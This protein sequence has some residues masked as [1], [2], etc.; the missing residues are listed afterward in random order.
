MKRSI[1]LACRA[2][3]A[4]VAAAAPALACAATVATG[5]ALAN[6]TFQS[7]LGGWTTSGVVGVRG[8]NDPINYGDA[9]DGGGNATFDGFFASRFAVLGDT[10]GFISPSDPV[11]DAQ[12]THWLTQSFVLD[13]RLEQAAVAGWRLSIYLSGAFDGRDSTGTRAN[14]VFSAQLLG[15]DAM[16]HPLF[17]MTSQGLG[18]CGPAVAPACGNAQKTVD[19]A[20]ARPFVLDGLQ[21]G[22]YTLT[23]SLQEALGGGPDD[24]RQSQTAAGIDDVRVMAFAELPAPGGMALLGAGLLGLGWAARRRRAARP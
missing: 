5:N 24:Y 9:R 21:P 15:P 18:T 4:A 17:S 22:R 13:S 16:L 12:G 8:A 7:G 6:G 3:L 11:S 10:S 19:R 14:D 20:T 2:A 23:F 1:Q